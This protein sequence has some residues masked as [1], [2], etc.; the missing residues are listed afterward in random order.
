MTLKGRGAAVR[1]GH[2]IAARRARPRTA[3]PPGHTWMNFVTA[4]KTFKLAGDEAD[5]PHSQR[6]HDPAMEER[7][8]I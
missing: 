7:H 6:L 4:P 5:R 3:G 1:L 2:A 8:G